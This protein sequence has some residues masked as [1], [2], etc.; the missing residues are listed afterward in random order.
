MFPANYLIVNLSFE[1]DNCLTPL[2]LIL[3]CI[4]VEK[5]KRLLEF[6]TAF[7][8]HSVPLKTLSSILGVCCIRGKTGDVEGDSKLVMLQIL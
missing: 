7:V 8:C 5:K 1:E 6:N 3:I 2:E 4:Y